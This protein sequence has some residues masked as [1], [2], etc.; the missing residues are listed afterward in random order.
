MSGTYDNLAEHPDGR[1]ALQLSGARVAATFSTSRSPVQHWAKEVPEPLFTVPEPFR[2]PYP[3]LR[4]AEGTPVLANGTPAPDHPEPRRFLLRFDPDG[5][6]HYVDDDHV[7]GVGYLA[8]TLH[9]VWGTTPAANDQAVLEILD[10]AWFEAPV[11]ARTPP[12][13]RR[14]SHI[15]RSWFKPRDLFVTRRADGRVTELGLR[16][17]FLS[18]PIPAALGELKALQYLD[19]S[20]ETS[21]FYYDRYHIGL[22]GEIPSEIGQL[23]QLEYLNLGGNYLTGPIP[24]ELGQL[25]QLVELDLGNNLLTSPIPPELG[26][27]TQL[28]YL[29][30]GGNLLTGQVP[31]E[32]GH[33]VRLHTL[34]LDSHD[35]DC[36]RFDLPARYTADLELPAV[37]LTGELPATLGQLANLSHLSLSRNQFSA[38][39]PELGQLTNLT[40]LYA[41]DNRLLAL[42]PELGQ[43]A[44]L[45]TLWLQGNQLLAL[46]PELGQ[47]TKLSSLRL[48]GNALT[49]CLPAAWR[50][51]FSVTTSSNGE[52]RPLPYCPD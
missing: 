5:A 48:N 45:Q 9:T 23:A 47:L 21:I 52:P 42:P 29:R 2:P 26:Q 49:G 22:R 20:L 32:L 37:P 1:Y 35:Y 36:V 40:H 51:R 30:L 4:T 3:V 33:L 27:L 17:H 44:S 41:D 34:S 16:N 50:D 6:V 8:Y 43:L 28:E 31:P 15:V 11:L 13:D 10:K 19:I 14:E 7:E 38:L 24:P 25:S 18:H 39:P 46:P 12:P